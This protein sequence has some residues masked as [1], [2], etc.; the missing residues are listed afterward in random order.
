MAFASP[1]NEL[2]TSSNFGGEEVARE[3]A[4]GINYLIKPS[5][6]IRMSRLKEMNEL[7][8]VDRLLTDDLE[9]LLFL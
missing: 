6:S 9:V 3:R 4:I 7:T 1:S 2:I 5:E 8:E